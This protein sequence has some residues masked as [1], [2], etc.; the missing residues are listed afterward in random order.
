MSPVLV[1]C[2][3]QHQLLKS[4]PFGGYA[5]AVWR[6]GQKITAGAFVEGGKALL[7]LSAQWQWAVR[8]LEELCCFCVAAG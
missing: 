2:T 6:P 7:R 8:D 3:T 4:P 1:P 5:C